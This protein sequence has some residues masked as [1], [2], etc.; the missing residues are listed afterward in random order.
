M[1]TL[2]F[3]V[4]SFFNNKGQSQEFA[5]GVDWRMIPAGRFWESR[6]CPVDTCGAGF[7]LLDP[8]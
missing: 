6:F 3:V 5:A 1:L 8:S 4:I 2:A 7:G